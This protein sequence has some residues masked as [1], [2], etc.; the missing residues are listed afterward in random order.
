[1]EKPQENP[2]VDVA[3]LEL[4]KPPTTRISYIM[5]TAILVHVLIG[6]Y[7]HFS[8]SEKDGEISYNWLGVGINLGFILMHGIRL[9]FHW[10]KAGW[11]QKQYAYLKTWQEI[12][13]TPSYNHDDKTNTTNFHFLV[14]FVPMS[15][16]HLTNKED[17]A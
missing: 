17:D 13:K 5:L 1:M 12:I 14:A 15:A 6:L 8:P 2:N 3:N 7:A 4:P 16:V 11:L 10:K 9:Y